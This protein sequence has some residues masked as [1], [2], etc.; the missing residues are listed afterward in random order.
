MK[1]FGKIVCG[2]MAVALCIPSVA[3]SDDGQDSTPP[4]VYEGLE[5]HYQSSDKGL[6]DFLNDFS[7]RHLRYDDYSIGSPAVGDG[8]MFAK[9][10][11]TESLVWHNSTTAALGEDKTEKIY[12]SLNS[13]TQ[14]DL[15]MIYNTGNYR[16]AASVEAGA[17]GIP[18]GWP[19]PYWKYSVENSMTE[20]EMIGAHGSISFEFNDETGAQNKEWKA[21]GGSFKV[22][23]TTYYADFSADSLSAGE[24]F[25]FY[26]ENIGSILTRHGGINTIYS[27]MLEMSLDFTSK[28]LEDYYIIWKTEAGGDEWFR[29][30]H[31]DLVTAQKTY[32]DNYSDR[33]YFSM[34]LNENWDDQIVTALGIEFVPKSGKKLTLD[35]SIDYIRCNYDTRQ[36]NATYQWILSLNNYVQ[37]TNDVEA[38]EALMPKARRATLFLTHALQGEEGLLD[39]SYLY[40]HNGVGV[41]KNSDGSFT[42]DPANGIGNGYWDII[43][44]SEKDLEANVYFYR[45]LVAM[46]E[47]EQMV[48]DSGAEI[49]EVSTVRNRALGDAGTVEYDYTA[50]TLLALAERVKSNIEKDIKPVQES[51]GTYTN[52]GG[53]WNPETG[54]FAAGINEKNGKILDYGYVYWNEEAI[55]AGVGTPEQQKS[56]MSWING[57]RIVNGDDSTGADIYFYEFAPRMN[58]KDCTEAF[59]FCGYKIAESLIKDYGTTW[60][61]QVQNGGAVICWSYYDIVARA[62]VLGADNALNRLKEI[63]AWYEKVQKNTTGEGADFYS[64]YYN[65]LEW[66]AEKDGNAGLYKL[67]RAESIGPGVLGLDSEFIENV[68]FI[69][70]LPAAIFGMDSTEYNSVSFTNNLPDGLNYFQI[71]NMKFAN[72]VYSLC[73]RENSFEVTNLKGS[74]NRNHSIS[75][76]FYEPEGNYSVYINDQKTDEYTV[77]NGIITVKV[78][79]S[80]VTVTVK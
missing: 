6:A 51:D 73:A 44:S 5:L 40:G 62:K 23:P 36:S 26:R 58:T 77:N 49:S 9:N 13:I 3:C 8:T 1:A 14:D 17:A 29:V 76:N 30:S 19:F 2:L 32:L 27:P 31:N 68:L 75:L 4:E 52:E 22:N 66:E 43:A 55:C 69:K 57:D 71:D 28:N 78:P 20:F 46:A 59:S 41:T 65:D 33:C 56:I 37:Y 64:G 25:R 80:Q 38:L 67:Q 34:Y 15:G 45:A 35:G 48:T 53:F 47:L 72:C 70:A 11:E 74:T 16:E 79:F 10:W 61:R 63:Q 18:Q 12:N 42:V 24:S 60:P 50:E 21:E 39:I 7:H 54:R